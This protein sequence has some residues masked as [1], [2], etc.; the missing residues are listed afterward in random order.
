MN[1]KKELNITN[2][3]RIRYAMHGIAWMIAGV[4]RFFDNTFCRG[5]SILAFAISVVLLMKVVLA[6]RELEDE[7][8]EFNLY[9]AKAAT[10]D[11]LRI[12][13]CVVL[14]FI[15]VLTSFGLDVL[16]INV[17]DIIVPILF[18]VMGIEN[19]LVGLFFNHFD[20]E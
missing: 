15:V 5:I 17:K 20:K 13:V 14:I 8:A 11:S 4:F 16:S 6:N 1:H 3:I 2:Q 10:M 19:L 18:I 12:L 9:K 7:M